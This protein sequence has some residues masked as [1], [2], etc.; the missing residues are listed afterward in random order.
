VVKRAI[1]ASL[2]PAE[3]GDPGGLGRDKSLGATPSRSARAICEHA[4]DDGYLP[5]EG[6]ERPHLTARSSTSKPCAPKPEVR[7]WS[8]A[9]TPPPANYAACSADAK[10]TPVVLGGDGQPLD[11]GRE[12]RVSPRPTQ[13]H[14]R[15]RRR[16]RSSGCDR[17]PLLVPNTPYPTWLHGGKTDIDK[18][19]GDGAR[20]LQPFEISLRERGS[21]FQRLVAIPTNS[22]ASIA[23]A[24]T[25]RTSRRGACARG[26][27]NGTITFATMGRW[28]KGRCSGRCRRSR[29]SPR[30]TSSGR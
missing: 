11:V 21:G 9:D 30:P 3:S 10:I 4:L 2:T 19:G 15:P 20:H 13:S 5:A 8:S 17:T 24:S 28:R 23:L 16:L 1:R 26:A 6:G 27:S 14:C 12:K 29:G 25:F 22:R 18:L 7:S